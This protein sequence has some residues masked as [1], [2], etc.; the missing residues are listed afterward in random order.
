MKQ[1]H[2]DKKYNKVKIVF[3]IS[4]FGRYFSRTFWST[5]NNK[6]VLLRYR[7]DT[8]YKSLLKDC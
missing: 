1:K 7:Y 4:W 8:F 3:M 2:D 5:F 6:M